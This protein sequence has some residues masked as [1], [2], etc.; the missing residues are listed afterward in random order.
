[1]VSVIVPMYNERGYIERCLDS[2]LAQDYPGEYEVLVVDGRSHDGSERVVREYSRKHPRIRVIDNPHRRRP[3]AMNLG[4]RNARGDVVMFLG[5]HSESPPNLLSQAVRTLKDTGA[6]C[7]GGTIE[8]VGIGFIGKA[9]ATAVGHPLGVG[10][11]RYRYSQKA[12]YVDTMGYGVYWREV[13]GRIG[14]FDEELDTSED[15]ELNYRLRKAGGRIFLNPQMRPRYYARTSLRGLFRQY[16]RYGWDKVAVVRKHPGAFLWRYRVPPLFVLGAGTVVLLSP[17]F[18]WARYAL[19]IGG[20]TYLLALVGASLMVGIQ[21]RAP[22]ALVLP[23]AFACMHFGFGVGFLTGLIRGPQKVSERS[24]E[25][26]G[27]NRRKG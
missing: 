14:L 20:G 23:L 9:V 15:Y 17:L 11:S 19:L 27:A 3:H 12:Q 7:V 21:C 1:M 25:L 10:G 24:G 2:L 18:P 5:A 4:V 22:Y 13:F 16:F 6:E 26:F 8:T